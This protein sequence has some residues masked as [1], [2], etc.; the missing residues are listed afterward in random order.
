MDQHYPIIPTNS[1]PFITVEQMIEVDRLMMEEYQISLVQ[2]MEN[3]AYNL[4]LLS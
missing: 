2:M 1:I 4:A 3:A